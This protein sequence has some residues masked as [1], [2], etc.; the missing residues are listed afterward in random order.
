[1]RVPLA[2]RRKSVGVH[3]RQQSVLYVFKH[4]TKN[5]LIHAPNTRIAAYWHISNI[6]Q[7]FRGVKFVVT[8]Q[9]FV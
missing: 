9:Y 8:P 1:M 6:P 2:A 5:I 7:G 3:N 4:K